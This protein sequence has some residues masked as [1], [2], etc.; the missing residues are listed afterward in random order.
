[1]N[2]RGLIRC[3][4][5]GA[6]FSVDDLLHDRRLWP[7]GLQLDADDVGAN[8]FYFNHLDPDCGTTFTVPADALASLLPEAPPS[9]I[10][11]RTCDCEGHCVTVT[12][13]AICHAE[14][15]WAPYRRLLLR[16]VANR[17]LAPVT[18]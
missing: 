10:R 2:D 18:S 7:I 3:S 15:H 9:A 4:C 6:E 8:Y 17:S 11:T 13:H 12:D 14:C 1:M 16:M 5:C